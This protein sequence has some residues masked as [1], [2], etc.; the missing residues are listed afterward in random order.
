MTPKYDWVT[1]EPD[2]ITWKQNG[3][4]NI[5]DYCKTRNINYTTFINRIKKIYRKIDPNRQVVHGRQAI[6]KTEG[7]IPPADS[8]ERPPVSG[9]ALAD[10]ALANETL[11]EATLQAARVVVGEMQGDNANVRLKAAQAIL[12]AHG[13]LQKADKKEERSPYDDF[14]W[15]EIADRMK[16]LFGEL[17]V[18]GMSNEPLPV[19]NDASLSALE[20]QEHQI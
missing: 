3:G 17:Y 15:Q 19:V 14:S 11:N 4:T 7:G 5:R 10:H 13:L 8:L 1:I 12:E 20:T 9:R 2:F 16:A 18:K 6:V